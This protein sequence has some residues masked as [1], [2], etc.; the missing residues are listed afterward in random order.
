MDPKIEEKIR[1]SFAAQSLMT[2]LGAAIS[3]LEDGACT[4]EAP[5]ADHI[6]QQHGVAHAGA[7]FALGDSA[8]GYAALGLM[9]I[10]AEVMTAEM[11]I[12]L[13]APAGGERLI[14]EG[15]VIKPGRRL[16]IVKS[17]VF[18]VAG[19]DKRHVATLLG[20]MVPILGAQPEN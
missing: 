18:A 8:A 16:M 3:G 5:I 12:H 19:S 20:T 6:K 13:L 9:P 2:T 17:D 1:K 14:A 11:K 4:I 10:E 7:T 15:S